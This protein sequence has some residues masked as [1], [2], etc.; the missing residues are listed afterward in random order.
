MKLKKYL[1]TN[2]PKRD[3]WLSLLTTDIALHYTVNIVNYMY[4]HMFT[5]KTKIGQIKDDFDPPGWALENMY[6]YSFFSSATNSFLE[7]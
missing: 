2:K 1:F 3:D 4:A 5:K 7:D 6:N